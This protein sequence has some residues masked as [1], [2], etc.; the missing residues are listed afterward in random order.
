V[1]PELY[2]TKLHCKPSILK[3][4]TII[5]RCFDK[6]ITVG[7][8]IPKIETILFPELKDTGYL[9]PISRFEDTVIICI[10]NIYCKKN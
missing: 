7:S 6:I 4:H 9:F 2:T 3:L 8:M 10:I 1:E 5:S